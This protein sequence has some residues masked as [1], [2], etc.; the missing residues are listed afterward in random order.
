MERN[1]KKFI[2]ETQGILERS[3]RNI[4]SKLKNWKQSLAFSSEKTKFRVSLPR[5]MLLHFRSNVAS[6]QGKNTG[7]GQNYQFIQESL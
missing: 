6:A 3:K 4:V 1:Y 2:R 7:A 5:F